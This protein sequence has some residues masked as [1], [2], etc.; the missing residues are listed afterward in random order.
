MLIRCSSFPHKRES[1]FT[2]ARM[3]YAFAGMTVGV[4]AAVT[5]VRLA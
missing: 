5:I 3:D 4:H 2:G 1:V